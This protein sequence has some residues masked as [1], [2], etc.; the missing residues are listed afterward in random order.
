MILEEVIM[1]EYAE[2]FGPEPE[3]RYV[4]DI[5]PTPDKPG[6][7]MRCAIAKLFAYIT[8]ER[9]HRVLVPEPNIGPLPF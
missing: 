9:V 6:L 7:A 8:E 3:A 4:L 2:E 5:H 1:T